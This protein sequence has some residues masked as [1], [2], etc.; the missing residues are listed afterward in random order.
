MFGHQHRLWKRMRRGDQ[1]ALDEML[2]LYYAPIY[3]YLRRLCRCPDAAWDLTQETFAKVLKALPSQNGSSSFKAWLYR[4]ASN[5]WRDSVRRANPVVTQSEEWWAVQP[6]PARPH[7]LDLA[8]REQTE[9]LWQAVERLD[10]EKRETIYL[11]YCQGLSLRETAEAL[12]IAIP[13]VKYRL[14]ESIKS[15]REMLQDVRPDRCLPMLST[16]K[17]DYKP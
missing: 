16:P 14:R 9:L 7:A 1:A 15:L 10:A 8:E 4:I 11:H 6:S 3:A 17:E 5:V 2:H 13:T 12:G